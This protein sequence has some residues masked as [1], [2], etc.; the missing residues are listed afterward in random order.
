V[1]PWM[2]II[3]Y[4]LSYW[5]VFLVDEW[6]SVQH[7]SLLI[8]SRCISPKNVQAHSW[9]SGRE[10][11]QNKRLE[12]RAGERCPGHTRTGGGGN[13]KSRSLFILVSPHLHISSF[14]PVRMPGCDCNTPRISRNRSTTACIVRSS[15]STRAPKAGS[16]P[17]S[18]DC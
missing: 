14:K 1:M 2:F 6:Y 10:S 15:K 5:S 18:L 4:Y 16:M 9:K 11:I 8:H 7:E 17:R 12:I 3:Y 13:N